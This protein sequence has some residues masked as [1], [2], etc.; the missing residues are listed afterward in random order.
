MREEVTDR[1]GN[2]IY[3]TDERWHHIVERHHEFDGHRAEILSTV[4]SGNR[5]RDPLRLDTFYYTRTFPHLSGRLKEIEVVVAF[6]WLG[7]KPNNFVVT[8][9]PA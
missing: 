6:H 1:Y 2:V 3:L 7:D 5:S 9:Y 4:R 8:A